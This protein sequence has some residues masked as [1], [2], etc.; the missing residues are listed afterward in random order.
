MIIEDSHYIGGDDAISIKSGWGCFG[1]DYNKSSNNI[2]IRNFTSVF[3]ESGV[4]IGSEISGGVENIT[5]INCTFHN[6]VKGGVRIKSGKGRGAYVKNVIF[7]NIEVRDSLKL[8]K[9]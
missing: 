6:P 4:A 8:S 7:Q 2:L 5:V 1:L 9:N 3:G